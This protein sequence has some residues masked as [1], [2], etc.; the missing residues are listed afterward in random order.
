MTVQLAVKGTLVASDKQEL[1]VSSKPVAISSNSQILP[2]HLLSIKS[3]G[4]PPVHY[5]VAIYYFLG[6]FSQLSSFCPLAVNMNFDT[7]L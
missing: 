2:D 1:R 7:A 3:R 6:T 5:L 4:N